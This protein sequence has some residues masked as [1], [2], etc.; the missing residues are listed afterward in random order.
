MK[1][2]DLPDRRHMVR[3]AITMGIIFAV[4]WIVQFINVAD[5]YG[6]D[7]VL[8][9]QPHVLASLPDIF[10][11]PFLHASWAHIESNSPP[12]LVLGFLAAYRG[13]V[14]FAWVTGIVIVVAGLFVWLVGPTG[15]YTI[16]ASAVITG[17]LGYVMLRGVFD[18]RVIDIVVGA[19]A[20]FVYLGQVELVPNNEGVSWQ[21]HLGGLVTGMLCAWLISDRSPIAS[22]TKK[23]CALIAGRGKPIAITLPARQRSPDHNSTCRAP[24]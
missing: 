14:K 7:P 17:W 8:G 5:N 13:L 3:A 9:I 1:L 24:P 11:A 20:G 22:L 6:L 16:G 19:A 15:T 23:A 2:S 21:G 18:R 10:T 12:L 4:I